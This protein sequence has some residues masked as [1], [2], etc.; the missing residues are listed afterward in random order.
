VGKA[1]NTKRS[2]SA[3]LPAGTSA[4]GFRYWTD[5]AVHGTG[6]AVE[7]ISFQGTVD[8]ATS[9]AGSTLNRFVQPASGQYAQSYFHYYIA[10][11]R[12]YIDND[13]SLCGAY[14]F[15]YGNWRKKQCY[16]D[17]S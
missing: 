2:N 17:A 10:E 4:Y 1:T 16:A 9:T 6:F 11:S 15:L 14:N 3:T 5:G 8:D 12:S 13:T 7:S